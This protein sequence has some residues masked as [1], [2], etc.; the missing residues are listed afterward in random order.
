ML[1]SAECETFENYLLEEEQYTKPLEYKGLK[2]PEILVSGNHKAVD[3]YR[4]EQRIYLTHKL[5]PDL[6][7]K[8]IEQTNLNQ[9]YIDNIITKKEG[10]TNGYN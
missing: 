8:H 5:R 3:E 10:N 9:S 4:L 1:G 7:Q 2:V 6:L